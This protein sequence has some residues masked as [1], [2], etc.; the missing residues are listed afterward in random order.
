MMMVMM[1]MMMKQTRWY[2]V[3]PQRHPSASDAEGHARG[4]DMVP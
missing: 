4:S 2:I 1:M 3:V